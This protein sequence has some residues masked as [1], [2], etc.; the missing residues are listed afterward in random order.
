[1]RFPPVFLDLQTGPVL[2]VGGGDLVRAKLRLLAAAGASISWFATDG[3]YDLGGLDAASPDR[4]ERMAGDPLTAD[5]SG[6]I[7][8][9]CAGAG[10]VGVAMAARAKA[11][12]L[13]VNVMDDL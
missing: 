4:I 6:V 1:M 13:P 10:D 7:A 8:V 2:L 11:A 3:D 9:L 5:L 12:G